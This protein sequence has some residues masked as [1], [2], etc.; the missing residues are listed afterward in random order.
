MTT[1]NLDL[2]AGIFRMLD[3][4]GTLADEKLVNV[5]GDTG[6]A[7]RILIDILPKTA[8]DAQS[9]LTSKYNLSSADAKEVV[10]YTHPDDPRPVIFVASW[11]MLGKAS[12]WTFFGA[13][14]FE[15][16]TSE[17]YMY[18]VPTEQVEV[19][20]G[21]TGKLTLSDAQ[22]MKVNAVITRGNGNNTTT[23][24]TE[25]LYS[26]NDKQIMINDTPY[27]PYN[28]SNIIVI[29][30]GYL[31]KNESVGD[32]KDANFTLFLTRTGNQYSAILMSNELSNSMFTRLYLMGGAGQDIFESVHA[33]NGVL[34]YK[35]N[36]D[37]T[38]AGSLLVL[39]LGFS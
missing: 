9:T 2:S 34:L 32:V 35:V 1:D 14:N 8:S 21:S 15:N 18:M 37:K 20:E 38:K 31:T 3:T 11:D 22:G 29:E 27:N 36:F 28:I 24:Y 19:K 7:T 33:E 5:T 26:E 17:N 12:W 4:T 6:K 13:W 39:G 16:Q 25:A 23:A 30:D 10:S